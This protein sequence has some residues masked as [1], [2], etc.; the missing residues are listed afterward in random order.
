MARV[1]AQVGCRIGRDL[2]SLRAVVMQLHRQ[3]NTGRIDFARCRRLAV[4]DKNGLMDRKAGRQSK[5]MLLMVRVDQKRPRLV[6]R[7]VH[8]RS[9]IIVPQH[10]SPKKRLPDVYR[11]DHLQRP[12]RLNNTGRLRPA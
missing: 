7:Q 4:Q 12:G 5:P 10:H 1:A 9:R 2:G 11:V 3:V 6:L 8:S